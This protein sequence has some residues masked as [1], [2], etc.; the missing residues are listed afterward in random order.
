ME[1]ITL[2]EFD[3]VY[4]LF[5][6]AFIPAELRPYEKM[7]LLFLEDEFVIYGMSQDEKIVGAIIVWEF[8]DFV[9]LE[10]FAVDQSLRGQGLGSQILQAVKELYPHQ[11]LVLEVEEPID[12]L[13]KR[14]VA[15]Y[16]RNQYV[17]NPYHFVQPP[18]RKNA[19]KVELMYMS[20]PDSINVYAFD[21]I[22]KQIFRIVYQ[23]GI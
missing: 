14:R 11:L 20:Y 3:E 22:K 4:A 8:N 10:N 15:F 19:P 6:K 1:K 17:L 23:Q 21:Q 7:K 18:L 12:D 9:Y 2:K 5:D 13:T 16:Q